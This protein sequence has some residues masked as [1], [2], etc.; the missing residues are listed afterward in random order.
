MGKIK[1]LTNKR[2]GLLIAKYP[3]DK[4]I[5][6]KVVWL[7]QC[8]CGNTT[9]VISSNLTTGRT[10]SCG[11][12]TKKAIGEHFK[13]NLP[14]P[15]EYINKIKVIKSEQR[16][17][18][19]NWNEIW[20][21]GICPFCQK[22]FWAKASLLRRGSTQSCGCAK[23]SIGEK[24][25]EKIL[26]DNNIEFE[27]EKTFNDCYFTK[28]FS[29]C[30]FDFYIDNKYIIEFDGSQH[31]DK[32]KTNLSSSIFTEEVIKKIQA[33]DQYKNNYCKEKGI[34]LIRIPYWHRD[35]IRLEDLL[36]E[37]SKFLVE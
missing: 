27:T 24:I 4:R 12:N 16:V 18:Y 8:D 19:H 5:N 34:P 3:T 37:T 32:A 13:K 20:V 26:I 25:I 23:K 15:G 22:E 1:D 36:L 35:E 28:N 11:C 17:G 9:E 31:F 6:R 2:F 30:R 29:K 33:R 7:C 14:K 21:L 10:T